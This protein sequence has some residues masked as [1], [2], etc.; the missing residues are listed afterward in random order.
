[1]GVSTKVF[2]IL[3]AACVAADFGKII[4]SIYKILFHASVILTSLIRLFNT[5]FLLKVAQVD[6][7]GYV[8]ECNEV[9]ARGE[10]TQ[11]RNIGECCR[12]R[13]HTAGGWCEKG[14]IAFCQ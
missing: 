6:A 4:I 5:R 13:G 8:W 14:D 12:S 1:M 2:F 3:V 11:N 10:P 7:R 9:C